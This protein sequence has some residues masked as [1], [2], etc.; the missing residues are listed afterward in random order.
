M[1][2]ARIMAMGLAGV[3]ALAIACS[4]QPAS[5]ASPTGPN[6]ASGD[7]AADGSTLKT[8]AP[9]PTSPINDQALSDAP[10]LSASAATMKFGGP[11][12][13]PLAY[14]FQVFGPTGATVADSGA[15]GTASYRVT[16][17]LAFKTRHTWRARAEYGNDVGPW[18]TTASFVSSEG[19]TSAA[20]RCLIR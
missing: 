3:L 19:D 11:A 12:P 17:I 4:R 18:S 5:P 1:S 8:S 2:R 10:T 13:G 14:R 15:L 20:T 16:A 6:G 7:A 9:V